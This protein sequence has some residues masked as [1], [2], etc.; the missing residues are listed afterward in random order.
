MRYLYITIWSSV[1]HMRWARQKTAG[2]NVNWEFSLRV[3]QKAVKIF[4]RRS[5]LRLTVAS[6]TFPLQTY[7]VFYPC[8][9]YCHHCR[10]GSS[11]SD[12][13]CTTHQSHSLQSFVVIGQNRWLIRRFFSLMHRGMYGMIATWEAFMQV[14]VCET[15]LPICTVK[16][17]NIY[18]VSMRFF[19]ILLAYIDRL[20]A[21]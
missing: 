20:I 3:L 4:L 17:G 14:L 13:E 19:G 10:C 11:K 12:A 8:P 2:Q 1:S 5:L 21:S 6:L 9:A 15:S 7:L 18:A 16:N